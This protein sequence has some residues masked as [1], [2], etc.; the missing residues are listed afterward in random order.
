MMVLFQQRPC[1]RALASFQWTWLGIPPQFQPVGHFV[2]DPQSSC[3]F[4]LGHSVRLMSAYQRTPRS[5][6]DGGRKDSCRSKLWS[7]SS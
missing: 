4:P 7:L 1:C 6:G 5:L 3:C 2:V